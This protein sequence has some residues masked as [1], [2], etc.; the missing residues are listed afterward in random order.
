MDFPFA[1]SNH[2][3]LFGVLAS[4]FDNVRQ[5]TV[6]DL[7]VTVELD[8]NCAATLDKLQ[9]YCREVAASSEDF[10]NKFLLR[11]MLHRR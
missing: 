1:T 10:V 5:V 7:T 4:S 8:S 3:T 9:L 2:A 11:W 6:R